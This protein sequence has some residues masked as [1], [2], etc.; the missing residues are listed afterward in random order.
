MVSRGDQFFVLPTVLGLL[1]IAV[2]HKQ[3]VSALAGEG[4]GWKA[5]QLASLPSIWFS[6]MELGALK[7][8]LAVTDGPKLGSAT[9]TFWIALKRILSHGL[10]EML[11]M[12]EDTNRAKSYSFKD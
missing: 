12:C 2:L 4:R 10:L 5:L 6:Q 11:E 8:K 9:K 7:Q 3:E 1:A